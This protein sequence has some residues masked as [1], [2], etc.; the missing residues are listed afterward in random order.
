MIVGLRRS[1]LIG[2]VA[3]VAAII[4]L[5]PFM[6]GI[7]FPLPSQLPVAISDIEVVD[8]QDETIILEVS[9]DVFNPDYGALA[10]SK[11]EYDLFA[12]GEFVGK[13]K[14]DY[15]DIPVTGQPQL[16][17]RQMTTLVSMMTIDSDSITDMQLSDILWKA[18]GTIGISNSIVTGQRDFIAYFQ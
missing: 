7:A 11:I 6:V 4:V 16:L 8:Q 2:T 17:Q 3:V 14:L 5:L 10:A 13:G 1:I 9:F 18:S 12:N 15:S